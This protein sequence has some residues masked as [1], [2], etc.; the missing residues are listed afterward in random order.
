MLFTTCIFCKANERQVVWNQARSTLISSWLFFFHMIHILIGNNDSNKSI[1]NTWKTRQS[2]SFHTE[3]WRALSQKLITIETE[4]LTEKYDFTQNLPLFGLVFV[5][6]IIILK[7]ISKEWHS[8]TYIE[9]A[10][11]LQSNPDWST[12]GRY[13]HIKTSYNIFPW[14]FMKE[15]SLLYWSSYLSPC[16]MET[17]C[18]IT[19]NFLTSTYLNDVPYRIGTHYILKQ[20]LIKIS[21][22]PEKL[23]LFSTWK[24]THKRYH[25]YSTFLHTKHT[26]SHFWMTVIIIMN[27]SETKAYTT[28]T[29]FYDRTRT[30]T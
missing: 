9:Y 5:S 13:M 28:T 30:M 17:H 3:I 1:I 24:Q 26:R 21:F 29:P 10:F 19:G 14:P 12:E 16:S 11:T 2:A 6:F 8:S 4:M 23:L 7:F 25:Y 22:H 18:K 15:K 27:L 20:C